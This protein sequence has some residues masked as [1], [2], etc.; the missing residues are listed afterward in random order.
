MLEDQQLKMKPVRFWDKFPG[1]EQAE[2]QWESA[3]QVFRQAHPLKSNKARP[4]L[5]GITRS[6][7]KGLRW[8]ALKYLAR[9]DTDVVLRRALLVKPM[10]HAFGLLRSLLRKQ[11]F[12]RDGD[13]FLYGFGR[14]E[15]FKARLRADPDLVLVVGFSYC[16]KPFECPSGRFTDQCQHDS[17]HSVCGQ[18]FIGKCVHSLPV[19]GN[20]LLFIPTVHFIAEKM[21][22]TVAR[23]PGREVLFVITACELTLE[24][25]ADSG[26][27][28][29]FK[30]IGVRLDGV[31]CNTMR[32][33]EASEVGIKPGLTFVLKDT[34]RRM[35]EL[36]AL[37]R[38][39]RSGGQS[40]SP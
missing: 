29:G 10:R 17:T 26:N 40:R 3:E 34:Q 15:E 13:F 33:F 28:A 31:I 1:W 24:M 7:R 6:T 20:V 35:L 8:K 5:P 38:Q 37:R 19:E 9:H 21:L 18:C 36:F 4:N 39:H 32:A 11:P 30:G 2:A 14:A 25:F 16:H 22:E 12:V 23:H 27:M